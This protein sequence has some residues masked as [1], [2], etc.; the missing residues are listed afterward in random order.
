MI[1]DIE[2]TRYALWQ[3][4][5]S[6]NEIYNIPKV[7][8]EVDCCLAGQTEDLRPSNSY[9]LNRDGKVKDNTLLFHIA[10]WLFS[11]IDVKHHYMEPRF[12][13]PSERFVSAASDVPRQYVPGLTLLSG[14]RYKGCFSGRTSSILQDI[15]IYLTPPIKG[16]EVAH[17]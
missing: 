13:V 12:K 14:S 2:I 1:V 15:Y 10:I 7:K 17:V 5:M 8:I 3:Y 4:S 11:M 9:I 16:A 6:A